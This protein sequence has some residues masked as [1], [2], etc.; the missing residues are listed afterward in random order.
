VAVGSHRVP[1]TS[2]GD[3]R[4][5]DRRTVILAGVGLAGSAGVIGATS[6]AASA[7]SD[8]AGRDALR[9]ALVLERLQ[10]AFYERAA[11]RPDVRD[12][13]RQF[14]TVVGAHERAHA[15]F[16][17]DR[18]GS[19]VPA[20]PVF[21][22]EDATQDADQVLAHAVLLED[23]AVAAYN[24]LI[25]GLAKEPLR[26][27]ARIVSVEAR[28]AAWVRDLAGRDPAP[29]AADALLSSDQVDARLRSLGLIA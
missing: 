6:V 2:S 26:A 24:G 9:N 15:A 23:L 1:Q 10:A 5:L 19:D 12:E 7:G 14:V 21:R 4:R 20:P 27:V 18:L 28:H 11:R 22:L 16:L 17:T 29:R 3:D 25:V 13:L 8:E